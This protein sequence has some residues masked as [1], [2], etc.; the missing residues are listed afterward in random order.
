MINVAE[1]CVGTRALGPGLRS[2]VWVQGCPFRCRGCLAPEWIPFREARRA[3]PGEL[4]DELLADPD[5]TGLTLSGGEPMAQAEGLTAM[6]RAARAQRELS[7][8]CFTG[9]R[10]SELAGREDAEALLAEVDVLI[11]GRYVRSRDDDRGLRGSANQRIHQLTGRLTGAAGELAGGPRRAEVRVR[12]G[13]AL[14]VGV[15]PR[16]LAAGFGR[17]GRTGTAG[18]GTSGEE[19][20]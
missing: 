9:F 11:D 1:T 16:A 3:A 7:V 5:V 8:I 12:G 4:A 10:R 20:R 2:V 18:E 14:L 6:V 17:G 13:Q 15:P 19:H